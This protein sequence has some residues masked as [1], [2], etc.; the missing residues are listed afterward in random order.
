[1]LRMRNA[2]A[3]AAAAALSAAA[4]GGGGREGSG[5]RAGEEMNFAI[6]FLGEASKQ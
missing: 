5:E 3:V 4:G 6:A 2:T 1:M